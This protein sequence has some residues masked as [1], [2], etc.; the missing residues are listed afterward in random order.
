MKKEGRVDQRG[1]L[2]KYRKRE[3][4]PNKR[5]TTEQRGQENGKS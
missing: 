3:S 1:N 5:S 4:R 2:E